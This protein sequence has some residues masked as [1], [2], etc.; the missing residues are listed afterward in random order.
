MKIFSKSS[1]PAQAT[2]DEKADAPDEK[3]K[4]KSALA[5]L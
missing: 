4:K 5:G 1:E 3:P 2:A